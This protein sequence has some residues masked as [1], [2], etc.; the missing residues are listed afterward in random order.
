[1]Q[2]LLSVFW[3]RRMLIACCI[4]VITLAAGVASVTMTPKYRATSQLLLTSD[5]T[6][7]IKEQTA[8]V[9][10]DQANSEI[11]TYTRLLTSR[12]FVKTLVER[13]ELTEDPFFN[14]PWPRRSNRLPAASWRCWTAYPLPRC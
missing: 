10:Q 1:M 11:E 5:Q 3:R 6:D 8:T 12:S 9:G 7:V 4:V 14:P 2:D 13:L